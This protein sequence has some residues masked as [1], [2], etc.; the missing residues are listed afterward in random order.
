MKQKVGQNLFAYLDFKELMSFFFFFLS[1]FFFLGGFFLFLEIR[2]AMW[3]VHSSPSLA[4]KRGGSLL[5]T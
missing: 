1:L 4:F 5:V 3:Q 2:V